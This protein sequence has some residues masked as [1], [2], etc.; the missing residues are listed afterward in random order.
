M[1]SRRLAEEELWERLGQAFQSYGEPLETGTSF[2]YLGRVL[3][4]GDDDWLEVAGNLR[5]A[6]AIWMRMTSILSREG[7]EP[8]VSGL[9]FKAVIQAVVHAVLLFGAETWVLTPRT[10]RALSSFHHRVA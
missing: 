7:A 9:F 6:R 5:K 1:R 8:K 2:K 4:T 10:E 3:T